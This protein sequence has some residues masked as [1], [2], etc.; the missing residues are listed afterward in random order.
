MRPN[1]RQ[2][3]HDSAPLVEAWL[4]P[5]LTRVRLTSDELTRITTAADPK[6]AL[7]VAYLAHKDDTAR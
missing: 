4:K 2:S 7:R 5:T 3:F 1:K 6:E